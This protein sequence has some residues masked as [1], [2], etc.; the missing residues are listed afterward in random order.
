M[1]NKYKAGLYQRFVTGKGSSAEYIFIYLW[2]NTHTHTHTPLRSNLA[3][4]SPAALELRRL[5]VV[6]PAVIEC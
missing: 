2:T 3:L 1:G 5:T 6:P 4:S